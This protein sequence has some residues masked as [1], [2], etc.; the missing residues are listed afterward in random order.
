MSRDISTRTHPVCAQSGCGHLRINHYT[1]PD[2]TS[3]C[4]AMIARS[5]DHPGHALGLH[6]RLCGC[7]GF[8]SIPD[9]PIEGS[10]SL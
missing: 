7:P 4:D 3:A 10:V 5:P 6:K 8:V 2:G 1:R 9:V